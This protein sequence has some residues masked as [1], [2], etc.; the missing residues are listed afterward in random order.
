MHCVSSL[1]RLVAQGT[2][3]LLVAMQPFGTSL[4]LA[5]GLVRGLNPVYMASFF[6]PAQG[7]RWLASVGSEVAYLGSTGTGGTSVICRQNACT[8]V[9]TPGIFWE[10]G[11]MEHKDGP[12]L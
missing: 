7:T 6:D 11:W 12:S 10:C 8:G 9:M 3:Y 4:V 2:F 1:A 5:S